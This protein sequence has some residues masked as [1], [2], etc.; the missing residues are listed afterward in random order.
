M[1]QNKNYFL[2]SEED[3]RTPEFLQSGR[4][5]IRHKRP[6]QSPSPATELQHRPSAKEARL[7]AKKKGASKMAAVTTGRHILERTSQTP[8]GASP[9]RSN[10]PGKAPEESSA[11]SDKEVL[12]KTFDKASITTELTEFVKG[13]WR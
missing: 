5:D 1:P 12:G 4:T 11:L 13:S 7:G 2:S 6:V 8:P 9:Q 3:S 10:S